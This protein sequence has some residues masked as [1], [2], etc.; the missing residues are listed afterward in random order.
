M[1]AV[2]VLTPCIV[3]AA[4]T[5]AGVPGSASAHDP[6]AQPAEAGGSEHDYLADVGAKLSNPVSDVWAHFTQFGLTFSDGD[7][8]NG[9]PEVAGN[10]IYQPILPVPLFGEGEDRWTLIVR[11]AIPIVF[12]QPSPTGFN[13]FDRDSGIGDISLPI[14]ASPPIE[15]LLLGLGPTFLFPTSTKDVLGKRQFGIGPAGILGWKTKDWVAGVFPQYY[16]GI[17]SRGDQGSTPDVSQMSLL[18]FFF[19]N[20]PDAWQI[21]FNPT[22][23]FDDNATRGN[24]WNVPVGLVVTKTTKFAGRPL[25]LQFGLEYSVVSQ[26]DFGQRFQIKLNLIPVIQSLI[27]SPILGGG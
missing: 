3:L 15:H 17:G 6:D 25:K 12:G 8:N 19:Y 5:L 10:L 14:V 18:Y 7:L 24:K 9:D 2:R 27:K 21:G 13:R 23:A 1:K 22:I 26:D 4:L 16:F 20:L 11:P